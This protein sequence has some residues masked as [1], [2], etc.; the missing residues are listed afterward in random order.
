MNERRRIQP[1]PGPQERFSTTTADIAIYGGSAGGGK[2]FAL[3]FE[4]ARYVNRPG[5]NA[6][7]FRRKTTDLQGGGSIWDEARGIYPSLR[8]VPRESPALEWNFP[9]GSRVEFRH[10]VHEYSVHDHQSKQYAFIGFDELTQFSAMQFWYMFSR[11]RSSGAM[12]KR[13]RG[14]CNPDPDSFVRQLV[15]WWI[16]DDGLA[17]GDR[18]GVVRWLVRLDEKLLW[19]DTPEELYRLDP[20]RILPRGAHRE[21]GD[22]RPEPQSL[23]F[24]RAKAQDNKILMQA[25]P[26]YIARLSLLPGAQAKRLRDGNWDARDS[27]GDY[28]DRSWC[29]IV[30]RLPDAKNVVRRVRFWDKAATSPSSDNPDPDWT[31]GVRLALTD[32]GR[33]VVEDVVGIRAGPAEVDELMLRTAQLDGIEVEVGCWQD[34]GQ[35]G[36]VDVE[37]MRKL[38]RGFRFTEIRAAKDKRTYAGV[39]TPHAKA[40][41]VDFALREYLPEVFSEME[42][43]PERAHDDTMDALS[44]CFQLMFGGAVTFAYDAAPDDRHGSSDLRDAWDLDDDDDDWGASSGGR[45]ASF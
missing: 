30:D 16:G 1:Q 27:A 18:S 12:P 45:G 24:I 41:K 29:R 35:A 6:V 37:H 39:W 42:G 28:F 32:A 34:P 33:Y 19:A 8:G 4:A 13:V 14:T 3:C 25:D 22:A 26:G 43:F 10:L 7:I 44:G 20:L 2:S 23:T 9:S 31:R 21:P 15:D 36:V 5:Y 11:L 40:G 17:R 38:L